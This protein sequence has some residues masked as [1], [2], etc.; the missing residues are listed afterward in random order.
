MRVGIVSEYVRPW[1]GGISEHVHH[2]ARELQRRGHDATVITGGPPLPHPE[3]NVLRLGRA[4]TFTSNGA[5]SR[6]A[7][8]AFVWRMRELLQEL[9]FDVLHVHAPLD[10]VLPLTAA[11]AAPCPVVGTFHASFERGALWEA[12]YGDHNPL[13]VRAYERL[14]ARIAVS[15]EARRSL[16][17]YRPGEVTIL[18]NGVD[19]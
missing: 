8:G 14:A 10:P 12:L 5:R 9:S 4:L 11:L 19:T 17:Q 18:G 2:E 1:P 13:A 16:A 15:E 3:P 7:L 6:L